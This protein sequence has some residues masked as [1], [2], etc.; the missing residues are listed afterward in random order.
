MSKAGG[1]TTSAPTV[2]SL[3]PVAILNAGLRAVP[4]L[5]YALGVAGIAVLGAV[6]VG[7]LG[8][9]RA[10]VVILGGM[11][12]AMVLLFAFARLTASESP[13]ITAAGVFL[14]WAVILFFCTFLVFTA[15]AV[16]V[17]WPKPLADLMFGRIDSL[18]VP[19]TVL[20]DTWNEQPVRSNPAV[21]AQFTI[22]R[23]HFVTRIANY[24]WA[25][26]PRGNISL[27]DQ[28]G[29]VHGPWQAITS[30]GQ[31]GRDAVN[32][33]TKPNTRIPAGTYTIVDS[34]ISTWSYNDK[35]GGRGFSL[36]TAHPVD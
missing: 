8:S 4:A 25:G 33:E 19:D 5:K 17:R 24:H 7:V 27:R 11:F 29:K 10:A 28:S 23:P 22:D 1:R 26:N 15:T 35:S 12:V 31:G 18:P 3:S 21:P 2:R 9:T 13:T 32:W 30:A 20:F 16:A 34:D 14:L 36:V 6:V